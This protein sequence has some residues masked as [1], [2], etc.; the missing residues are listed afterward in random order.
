MGKS[1]RLKVSKKITKAATVSKESPQVLTKGQRVRKE[2]REKQV[3]KKQILDAVIKNKKIDQVGVAFGTMDDLA[4]A[5][6]KEE[7]KLAAKKPSKKGAIKQ[8]AL[9]A[10][11]MRDLEAM[12]KICN[13]QPF[14][15]DPLGTIKTHLTNLSKLPK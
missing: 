9:Y 13:Y 14:V 10:Q 2:K 11:R 12:D 4:A 15:A 6:E 3:W 8:G 1:A 5:I 7:V